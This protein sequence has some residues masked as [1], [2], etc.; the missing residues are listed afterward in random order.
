MQRQRQGFT[1]PTTGKVGYPTEEAAEK[2]RGWLKSHDVDSVR[3]RIQ[4]ETY[5]PARCCGQYHHTSSQ[6]RILVDV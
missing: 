6:P 2:A 3:G 5:G 4:L 1:C